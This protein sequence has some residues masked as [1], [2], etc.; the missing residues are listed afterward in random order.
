MASLVNAA[1]CA[2]V[3][4]AFWS[5]LGYAL[6]RHLLPRMLAVGAA[7]VLGWAVHSAAALPIFF[8][9]GFSPITVLAV[10][11]LCTAAAC[12]SL[13]LRSPRDE[14][15]DTPVTPVWAYAAA[16]ILALV[17]ADAIA[18]KF[19]GGGVDLAAPIFDHSK[20]SIIDSMMRQG[21]PAIN[22]IFGAAGAAGRLAYYYLWHF[23]A[24]ELALPLHASGWEADIAL[25]WFTAFAS[26][27]AMIALAVR[28]ARDSRAAIVV[29]ILAGAG[30]LR[31]AF[32]WLP[33][34]DKIAP[35]MAG[36][37]G[38]SGWLFQ[39]AWVPQ[40]LMAATCVVMSMLLIARYA[41]RPNLLLLLTIVL[42]VAA[43]FESSTYVG[44]VTF[45]IAAVAA[46]PILLAGID[47]E[48]RLRF[49]GAMALTAV[50]VAG[51][52]A[53]F[54]IDQLAAVAARHDTA[55]VVVRPF[56]VLG[57]MFPDRLRGIL[58]LP[59]Y[60]LLE[61]PVE[62]P[63][64]YLAGAISLWAMLRGA[65]CR[66]AKIVVAAFA[67][68]A[69]AGLAASWLLASTLGDIN[70]LAL[71]AVL[72]A[73]MI[74][75]VATAAGIMRSSCRLFIGAIALTG[76]ILSL[77][78][79]GDLIRSDVVGDRAPDASVFA[80]APELWAAVRRFAS[81]TARVADNPL[82]LQD[83]TR[84]P[85]NISWA[86][87]A[88]RSSCFAGREL[89]LAFAPLP[90]SRREAINKQF[91][92]I[93]AGNGTAADV[94]EMA[95]KYGCNVVVVVPQDGAWTK[96]PFAASPDY[97]LADSREGR[98]RIYVASHPPR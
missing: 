9:I 91:I 10:G 33:G 71:R 51:L 57:S 12:G 98:W 66:P 29:V 34:S 13:A 74:L 23:S 64:I 49:I 40:H 7:P 70:D 6:G 97:R 24:A 95:N 8:L 28:L 61:L 47:R 27:A 88:D 60:W 79:A 81:P 76:F 4:A 94:G 42:T 11:V 38:F 17:P 87:L 21:L 44:G 62:F 68:L 56:A 53:P 26:L 43:G 83:I 50:L 2:I 32:G 69:G 20:V 18:P 36:S 78:N 19:A 96:D 59:A 25:T 84:W 73:I 45:A 41:Q 35:V 48:Q 93:F 55:P 80:Q 65:I 5:L 46:L 54:V 30:S 86:L 67:C 37:T 16:A 63:A 75:I 22:P 72:P 92:R 31:T 52:V 89:A 3:A 1:L 90:A 77:P 82:F 14:K 85:V 39:S 15:T 58:N